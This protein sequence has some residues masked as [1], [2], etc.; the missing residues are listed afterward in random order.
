M[1]VR[2]T[3]DESPRVRL[4]SWIREIIA[5]YRVENEIYNYVTVAKAVSLKS[6]YRNDKEVRA[7]AE[8][9]GLEMITEVEVRHFNPRKL[10]QPWLSTEMRQCQ[11]AEQNAWDELTDNQKAIIEKLDQIGVTTINTQT[12]GAVSLITASPDEIAE[13]RVL[14][15][16]MHETLGEEIQLLLTLEELRRHE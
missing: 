2:P 3:P 16:K 1:P 6:F 9:R 7:L 11:K 13:G 5:K 10:M 8:V 4:V 14:R 15:E 12:S